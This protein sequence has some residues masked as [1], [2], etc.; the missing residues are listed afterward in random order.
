MKNLINFF[1]NILKYITVLVLRWWFVVTLVNIFMS[2]Q[3]KIN[4]FFESLTIEIQLFSTI[5]WQFNI[6]TDLTH[7]IDDLL[8]YLLVILQTVDSV[9]R[10]NIEITY[11]YFILHNK[12]LMNNRNIAFL[13]H[14][15]RKCNK[16]FRN[17]QIYD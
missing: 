3:N 7:T 2:F 11:W 15:E 10:L 17:F 4:D 12:S 13:H 8:H 6:I 16:S 14:T 5:Y 9:Y 1:F